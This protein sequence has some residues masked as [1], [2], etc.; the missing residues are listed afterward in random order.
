MKFE[1]I[2]IGLVLPLIVIPN[3]LVVYSTIKGYESIFIG[4]FIVIVGEILSVFIAK[5]II[6]KRVRIEVNKGLIFTPFMILLLS[7]FPPFSSATNP[8]L[9]TI[10]IPAGIIGGVCEEIIYRGYMISDMTSVYVQAFLWSLLHIFDGLYFFLWTI[11]IGI[12]LGLIAKRYGILPTILIH[13]ISNIIR[14][15]L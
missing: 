2:F 13:V 4:G 7:F 15:L 11:L 8:S 1:E 12:V 6:K 5:L 9:F 14:A 3:E 10:L